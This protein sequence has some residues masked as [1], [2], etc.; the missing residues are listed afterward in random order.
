MRKTMKK[1]RNDE[2]GVVTTETVI[3]VAVVAV[4]G[5]A[6][7][8]VMQTLLPSLFTTVITKVSDMVSSTVI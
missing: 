5:I 4:V 2:L 7:L 8:A 1:L 3:M 6:C